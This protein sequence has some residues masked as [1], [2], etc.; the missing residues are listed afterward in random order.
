MMVPVSNLKLLRM[1]RILFIKDFSCNTGEF[2][3]SLTDLSIDDYDKES[4]K[5]SQKCNYEFDRSILEKNKI[6]PWNLEPVFYREKFFFKISDI[7]DSKKIN[8]SVF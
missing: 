5:Y 2:R 8:S 4:V 7:G 3:Y 6:P 1:I